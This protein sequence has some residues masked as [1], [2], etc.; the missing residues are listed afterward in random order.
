MSSQNFRTTHVGSLPRG[1]A[2]AARLIA[3]EAGEPID[4]VEF[5]QAVE[6]RVAQMLAS[7]LDA[8]INW[9]NDGE[10]GRAGFQTYIAERMSGFGGESQRAPSLDYDEF[11]T[12]SAMARRGMGQIAKIRNAPMAIG[13][14]RYES[15]SAIE[16]ECATLAKALEANGL[17]AADGFLTAPSPG[18]VA[19]TLQ[20]GFYDS[21]ASY[22]DALKQALR[23][24]YKTILDAG[25]SLQIDAPD[26]AM[27]RCI[28][29]K[30]LSTEDFLVRV[31]EHLEAINA[32]I[33]GL[34]AARIRLHCCW[35]NWDGPHL[36]DVPLA[37]VL[38]ILTQAK[39]GAFS[40]PFANPRHQH[41]YTAL[42]A[43]GLPRDAL[44]LPGVID[45]TCNYVE[46]PEVIARRILESVHAIG[47]A[48]RVVPSTDCGF[49]T[50]A[51]YEFVA[52]ELVWE[53]LRALRQGAD[54]AAKRL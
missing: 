48:E 22:L 34:P 44:L 10:Q 45:T 36:H 9:V 29:F 38:P 21:H 32:A 50:F 3:R 8:G 6:E 12:Y 47:D 14:V 11:P 46:H 15:T 28:F 42:Q 39:V 13:D 24:E 19:T 54:L 4:E 16:N 23:V 41:E 35:G 33:D 51:G 53:K 37:D 31:E 43:Y 52:E 40:I 27:E 1:E 2:L 18:I 26:L 7:Q 30:H 49:G 17:S 25:F 20:N 5:S